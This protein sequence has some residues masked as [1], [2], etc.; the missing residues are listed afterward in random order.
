MV[1]TSRRPI[2]EAP[3]VRCTRFLALSDDSQ[4]PY[5]R[6]L[7]AEVNELRLRRHPGQP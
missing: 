5:W 7:A 4:R 3:H 2:P 1:R 6:D